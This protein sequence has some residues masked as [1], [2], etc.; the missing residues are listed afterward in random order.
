[1]YFRELRSFE[2]IQLAQKRAKFI[3]FEVKFFLLDRLRTDLSYRM[4]NPFT[5]KGSPFDE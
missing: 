5:P 4:F 1:M 2:L 3:I